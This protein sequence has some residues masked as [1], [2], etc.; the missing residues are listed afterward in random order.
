MHLLKLWKNIES[1]L[2]SG[3]TEWHRRIDDL[4]Q[5]QAVRDRKDGKVWADDEVFKA[6]LLAVLSAGVDW[7]RIENRV[8]PVLDDLLHSEL[9]TGSFL[10]SYSDLTDK[11]IRNRWRKW[12]E[13]RLATPRWGLGPLVQLKGAAR[14]LVC[15]PANKFT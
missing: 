7:S 4:G 11:R 10:E 3:L 8:L 5:V 1:R 15:C 12:F 6:L 13:E 14:K 2:D 9:R